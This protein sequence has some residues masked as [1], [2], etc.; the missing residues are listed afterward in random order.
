ME[1]RDR[2]RGLVPKGGRRVRSCS[3]VS[4][5]SPSLR[6]L[7]QAAGQEAAEV[8]NLRSKRSNAGSGLVVDQF[9][10]PVLRAHGSSSSLHVFC[11]LG[12]AGAGARGVGAG[13]AGLD[14]L[15]VYSTVNELRRTLNFVLKQLFSVRTEMFS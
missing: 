15:P 6:K 7:I 5:C 4:L 9:C 12:T 3:R 14:W 2:T 13:R 11:G 8:V 10:T 1:V